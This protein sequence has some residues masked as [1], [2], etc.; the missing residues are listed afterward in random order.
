MKHFLL[1]LFFCMTFFFHVPKIFGQEQE[2]EQ[3]YV[4]I[5]EQNYIPIFSADYASRLSLEI[6]P[7]T[8][9][10]KG[11]SLHIR[12]QPM[13]SQ[14]FLIGLGTYA[15]DLPGALVDLNKSNRD[16]GWG[17]RIRSAFSIYGE[18]FAKAPNRGFFIGEQLGLQSFRISND[19]EVGGSSN[20]NNLLALTYVG[21]S[22][23]PYKGSFYLKPW[24]GLGFTQ[25]IDGINT[26][27]SMKY[28]ISPWFP[29]FTVHAGYTF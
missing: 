19:R 15:L 13:I 27:G 29:F 25:K 16:E 4:Q 14:R 26:V 22:W 5:G 7:L 8:F 17:V 23:Y 20:F 2:Q 3:D 12:Y 1:A 28:D 9:L 24:A 6:D 18:L 21:Y 11:Y 10:S